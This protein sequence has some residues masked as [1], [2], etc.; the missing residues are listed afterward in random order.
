VNVL[1]G[2]SDWYAGAQK[3]SVRAVQWCG[4]MDSHI[5]CRD[6]GDIFAYYFYTLLIPT[7]NLLKSSDTGYAEC[8]LSVCDMCTVSDCI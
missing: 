8:G 5:S 6:W 3:V 1:L 4:Q 7:C 2:K